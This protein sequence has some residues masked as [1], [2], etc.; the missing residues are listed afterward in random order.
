MRDKEAI[1][2]ERKT[3]SRTLEKQG[4]LLDRLTDVEKHLRAQLVGALASYIGPQLKLFFQAALEKENIAFKKLV[5]NLRDKL[6]RMEKEAP[7]ML[8]QLDCERKRYQE[9]CVLI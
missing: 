2:V 5:E 7:E 3:L 4:K 6:S 1:E 8:A 9:V